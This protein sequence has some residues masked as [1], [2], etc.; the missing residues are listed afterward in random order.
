MPTA[1]PTSPPFR[2]VRQAR[3]PCVAEVP[4]TKT[5]SPRSGHSRSDHVSF[6]IASER[7]LHRNRLT[8][9]GSVAIVVPV[10]EHLAQRGLQP[11]A[12]FRSVAHRVNQALEVSFPM[13][14]ADLSQIVEGV[15]G[16]VAIGADRAS[17]CLTQQRDRDRRGPSQAEGEDR[18]CRGDGVPQPCLAD[19]LFEGRFVAA[20]R[21]SLKARP[22]VRCTVAAARR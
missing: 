2:F 12:D 11:L 8:L 5:E 6:R 9:N 15:T 7:M 4:F 1:H 21:R 20:N 14:L 13:S 17:E 3:P 19:P 10:A 16:G 18:E 22:L